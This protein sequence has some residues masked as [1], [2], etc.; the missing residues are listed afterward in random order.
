MYASIFKKML[1]GYGQF[2]LI[3]TK[4]DLYADIWPPSFFIL[5]N[6]QG[7]S[8]LRSCDPC[9]Y[10]SGDRYK[11]Y[12]TTENKQKEFYLRKSKYAL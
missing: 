7:L 1:G 11:S 5:L 12:R 4:T 8:G 9:A 6:V 10:K 2:D 3:K